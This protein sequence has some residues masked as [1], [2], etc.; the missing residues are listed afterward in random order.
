MALESEPKGELD[1]IVLVEIIQGVEGLCVAIDGL[2][3]AGP[4]PWGGG[5]IIW[6]G[7]STKR[8]IARSLTLVCE[9]V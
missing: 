1:D 9:P 4:K 7:K 6:S 5:K 8:E 2:R 3:V